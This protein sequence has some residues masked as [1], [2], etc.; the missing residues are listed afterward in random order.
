MAPNHS[1][2][3]RWDACPDGM[4]GGLA[5]RLQ[6]NRRAKSTQRLVG[7][8]SVLVLIAGWL[9][10]QVISNGQPLTHADV[11]RH[12]EQFIAGTLDPETTERIQQ[13]LAAC[14]E[15]RRLIAEMQNRSRQPGSTRVETGRFN[16]VHI[17]GR[18][19]PNVL[20]VVNFSTR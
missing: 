9:A 1:K 16:T 13:H 11:R 17:G 3:D 5:N 14:P 18:S 15:C 20:Y 10:F 6:A 4:L 12:A 7:V 2:H 8:A 19:T